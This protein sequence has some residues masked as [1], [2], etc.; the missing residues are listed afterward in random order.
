M[1]NSDAHLMNEGYQLG[2]SIITT[3]I[4]DFNDFMVFAKSGK[5]DPNSE[6]GGWI[7]SSLKDVKP[8][9][10]GNVTLVQMEGDFS[11]PRK[12]TRGFYLPGIIA[13]VV[14][15][16]SAKSAMHKLVRLQFRQE[17]QNS[18]IEFPYHVEDL[19]TAYPTSP[20]RS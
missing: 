9:D 15:G 2:P 19:S 6:N 4:V 14:V 5:Q 3:E 1:D 18:Y 13:T 20:P 7:K 8:D 17:S 12:T 10:K 16:G 11:I